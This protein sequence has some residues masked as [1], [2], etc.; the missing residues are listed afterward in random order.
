MAVQ[1][2]LYAERLKYKQAAELWQMSIV[3]LHCKHVSHMPGISFPDGVWF[4]MHLSHLVPLDEVRNTV[5]VSRVYCDC[6]RSKLKMADGI[7][8]ILRS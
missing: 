2:Q 4:I 7:F 8:V 6:Q 5:S 1:R 3:S